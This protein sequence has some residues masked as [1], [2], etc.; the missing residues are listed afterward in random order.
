MEKRKPTH[1]LTAIK[2]TFRTTESLAIT[3]TATRSAADLGFDRT[4]VVATVQSIQ[5]RH[6]HKSMTSYAD[7]TAWQDVYFVPSDVGLL[8]V[9][10]TSHVVT[11]F[12]LLSFKEKD[13]A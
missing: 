6:F 13:D 11:E 9:K 1:D 10:F 3:T 2:A 8:Y 4:A 7:H 12:L 5:P